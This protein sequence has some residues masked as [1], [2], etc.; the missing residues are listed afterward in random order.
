MPY[1]LHGLPENAK[2]V[3]LTPMRVYQFVFFTF[4][5]FFENWSPSSRALAFR[6]SS[7]VIALE[8]WLGLSVWSAIELHYR[9]AYWPPLPAVVAFG[10]LILTIDYTTFRRGERWR[11]YV[12]E[13]ENWPS[14]ALTL[15]RILVGGTTVVIIAAYFYLLRLVTMLPVP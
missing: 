4:Y 13:F 15:G 12:T 8:A 2:T 7:A 1:M 6:A 5:Q 3:K 14:G 11:N 10:V 9:V